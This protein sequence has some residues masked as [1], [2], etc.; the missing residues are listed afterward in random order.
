MSSLWERRAR[1]NHIFQKYLM[2]YGKLGWLVA[3]MGDLDGDIVRLGF[4]RRMML[5]PCEA[6]TLFCF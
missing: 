2:V 6:G 1:E 4:G 3:G 5:K